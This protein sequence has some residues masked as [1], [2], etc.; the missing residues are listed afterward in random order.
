MAERAH[1]SVLNIIPREKAILQKSDAEVSGTVSEQQGNPCYSQKDVEW[2]I[3]L[4]PSPNK[5]PL[6]IDVS[7]LLVISEQKARN[8]EATE[9]KK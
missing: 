4:E 9:Y 8:Q 2:R 5:E 3:N 7:M 6:P 1:Q